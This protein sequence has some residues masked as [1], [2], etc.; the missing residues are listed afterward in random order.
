[1]AGRI[2]LALLSARV[3]LALALIASGI[4]GLAPR[5]VQASS[6]RVASGGAA[7]R[8]PA[9]DVCSQSLPAQSSAVLSSLLKNSLP[10][11][12]VIAPEASSVSRLPVPI[13]TSSVAPVQTSPEIGASLAAMRALP[14]IDVRWEAVFLAPMG[15]G[16]LTITP[17]DAIEG[18]GTMVSTSWNF[19]TSGSQI[20]VTVNDR[21]IGQLPSQG[22]A[23]SLRDV[24]LDLPC[25]APNASVQREGQT[26]RIQ[27][28]LTAGSGSE[29]MRQLI[30]LAIPGNPIGE[31][32]LAVDSSTKVW[33][34][35]DL[36]LTWAVVDVDVM[37]RRITWGPSGRMVLTFGDQQRL[38]AAR[39]SVLSQLGPS[40]AQLV[41][42]RLETLSPL[43]PYARWMDA[44]LRFLDVRQIRTMID[45]DPWRRATLVDAWQRH[46]RESDAYQTALREYQTWQ[47]Q[48]PLVGPILQYVFHQGAGS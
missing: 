1:M 46:G 16:W 10:L 20:A 15:S 7:T 44:L 27:G 40:T 47:E 33:Q 39:P 35:L 29:V 30:G 41:F 37:G 13:P 3:A 34:S 19:Q 8:A 18:E 42:A 38:A 26:E 14:R 22:L 31:M 28:R 23:A 36:R 11:I 32:T 6:L 25:Y 48:I 12:S 4:S 21:Q 17:P 43:Q 24:L 9:A 2:G 45:E 5:S